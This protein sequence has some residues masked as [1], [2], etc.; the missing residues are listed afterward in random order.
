MSESGW[1]WGHRRSFPKEHAKDFGAW[2][3]PDARLRNDA[4]HG[5]AMDFEQTGDFGGRLAPGWH[6]FDD[7]LLLLGV[8]FGFRPGTR[9]WARASWRP[10]RVRSRIISRSNSAKEPSIC[11]SMRPAG[12]D[13]SID[14]ASDRN[15]ALPS[16]DVHAKDQR[17]L[18]PSAAT[19]FLKPAWRKLVGTG[20]TLDHRAY[21]VAAM[22]TLRDRLR[23]GD[24]WVEGSRAFRAFDDYLLPRETF[25][26]RRRAG[27]LG[28]AVADRFD[29]WR[30]ERVKLLDSRLQEIDAL[31][32]A[33][34]AKPSSPPKVFRSARSAKSRPMNPTSSRDGSM[35]C[36]R[37]CASPSFSPKCTAGQGSPIGSVICAPERRPKIVWRS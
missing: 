15:F 33:S 26:A 22:M 29:D 6:G 14:S 13:V 31:A 19:T 37:V 1:L 3:D 4:R 36:C 24:I 10:A 21:E 12:P 8:I 18:P 27:E 28:L 35:A 30:T 25:A 23:S 34:S 17:K 16:R 9:P 32:A 7:L 11:I 20:A 5:C 2:S